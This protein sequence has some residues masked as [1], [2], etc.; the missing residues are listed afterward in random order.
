MYTWRGISIDGDTEYFGLVKQLL[1]YVAKYW[2][3]EAILQ[4][5][6]DVTKTR[7]LTIQARTR[8]DIRNDGRCLAADGPT[9]RTRSEPAD[10][11]ESRRFDGAGPGAGYDPPDTQPGDGSDALVL[12]SPQ[13]WTSAAGK[14]QCH[15]GSDPYPDVVLVH[16]L[17]HA[18]RDMRGIN[19]EKYSLAGDLAAY[20]NEDEFMTVHFENT[21]VSAKYWSQPSP[22]LRGGHDE[23][24]LDP[25]YSTSE[26]FLSN[27]D[28]RRVLV[29][30]SNKEAFSL[31]Q[32]LVGG[33]ALFNPF[34]EFIANYRKWST[35]PW[36]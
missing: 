10:L 19:G 26:G 18:V 20:D 1:L 7:T 8:D 30:Q 35:K 6:E 31:W 33:R 9:D 2:P 32:R 29:H 14:R 22:A 11:D 4:E 3:G 25:E 15:A 16:E 27:P 36:Y 34:G 13:E 28:F 21:Y 23:S 17:V 12:Y 5:I 24:T